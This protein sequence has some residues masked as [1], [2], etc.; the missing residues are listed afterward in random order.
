MKSVKEGGILLA[1]L[2]TFSKYFFLSDCISTYATTML[3]IQECDIVI[4]AK[5]SQHSD[6]HTG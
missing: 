2:G 3:V 4:F 1:N 6:S 5:D